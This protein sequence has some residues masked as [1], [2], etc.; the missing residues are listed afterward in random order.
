VKHELLSFLTSKRRALRSLT[1]L[2]RSSAFFFD[3]CCVVVVVIERWFGGSILLSFSLG[4]VAG[5]G[6]ETL[7]EIHEGLLISLPCVTRL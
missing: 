1:G 2:M 7:K 6:S 4:G 5:K 3:D